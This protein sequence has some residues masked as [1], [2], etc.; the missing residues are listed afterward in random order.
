[1]STLTI[2]LPQDK[3]SGLKIMAKERGISLNKLME[4][5]STMALAEFDA[6]TRFKVRAMKGS[7]QEGLRLL[8]K[9]DR[10]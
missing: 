10:K 6:Y 8:D 9:L 4:E 2:R 1:M 7:R 3:H 5:L